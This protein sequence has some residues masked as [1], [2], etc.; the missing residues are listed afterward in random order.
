MIIKDFVIDRIKGLISGIGTI[1]SAFQKLFSG[2]FAGAWEDARKGFV[3]LSGIDAAKKAVE[4]TIGLKD[5]F[6]GKYD[7]VLVDVAKKKVEESEGD[8]KESEG[9]F[10]GVPDGRMFVVPSPTYSNESRSDRSR[11]GGSGLEDARKISGGSQTKSVTINIES[12]VKGFNP[13]SQ[14]VNSM[15]K[16]ELER[17]MT[18]MFLRVVRSAEMA[19]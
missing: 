18:E 1:G 7:E 5:S 14:T 17:W 15:D 3:E 12:F 9:D 13:S 2:D 6:K 11:L 4:G 10:A 8:A 19:M 16:S